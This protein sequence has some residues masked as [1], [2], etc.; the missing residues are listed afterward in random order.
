MTHKVQSIALRP[1]DSDPGERKHSAATRIREKVSRHDRMACSRRDDTWLERRFTADDSQYLNVQLR[2]CFTHAH[3]LIPRVKKCKKCSW[4]SS[5]CFASLPLFFPGVHT[6][7][8]RRALPSTEVRSLFHG[9]N[10]CG[11]SSFEG[12]LTVCKSNKTTFPTCSASQSLHL[13]L[14]SVLPT[15]HQPW[16][17]C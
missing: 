16:F 15:L 13:P 6:Y 7:E 4:R 11:S 17:S 14:I 8:L 5:G 12:T 10:G 9:I 3:S 1:E 2:N